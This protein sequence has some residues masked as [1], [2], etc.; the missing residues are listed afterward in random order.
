MIESVVR[1]WILAN[2]YYRNF[3]IS[4]L[5]EALGPVLS[6]FDDSSFGGGSDEREITVGQFM[7]PTQ[8]LSSRID[9]LLLTERCELI[10]AQVV[11]IVNQK[12]VLP[13]ERRYILLQIVY[14]LIVG[15]GLWR[16]SKQ[17]IHLKFIGSRGFLPV[18]SRAPWRDRIWTKV[19][20]QPQGT[21]GEISLWTSK[22]GEYWPQN[23]ETSVEHWYP[24]S[25]VSQ[26]GGLAFLGV[27]SL[28]VSVL[29]T[30]SVQVASLLRRKRL[31]Q[32]SR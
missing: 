15:F 22:Y 1:A 19:I 11:L 6:A 28:W 20:S 12:R 27:A 26:A 17:L 31:G 18:G 7:V 3:D 8:E 24:A 25:T 10:S 2:Y 23:R 32:D 5:Q 14:C 9:Q 13:R 16:Y 21:S 30:L 29:I 4:P